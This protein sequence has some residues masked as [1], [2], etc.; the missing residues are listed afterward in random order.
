MRRSA[1]C[2]MQ[3]EPSFPGEFAARTKTVTNT[4]QA[5]P[6]PPPHRPGAQ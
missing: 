1:K 3:R 4:R 6:R 2:Y 5:L